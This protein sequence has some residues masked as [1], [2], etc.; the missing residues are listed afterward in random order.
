MPVAI[1]ATFIWFGIRVEPSDGVFVQH[2]LNL[3]FVENWRSRSRSKLS[4]SLSL[5]LSVQGV[6]LPCLAVLICAEFGIWF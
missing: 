5:L 2:T 4:L 3:L 6:V 1:R